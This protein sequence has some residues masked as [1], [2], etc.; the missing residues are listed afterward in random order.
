MGNNHISHLR[1]GDKATQQGLVG[2]I[3]GSWDLLGLIG[4]SG[5]GFDGLYERRPTKSSPVKV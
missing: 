5:L 4:K 3:I 2:A 1:E